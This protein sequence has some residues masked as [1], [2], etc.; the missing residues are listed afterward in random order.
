MVTRW[1]SA[2]ALLAVGACSSDNGVAGQSQALLPGNDKLCDVWLGYEIGATTVLGTHSDDVRAV[3]GEPAKKTE[4]EFTYDWCVGDGCEKRASAVLKFTQADRCY[5]D[6][7]KPI[8]PPMWLHDVTV[9]GFTRPK[10]W[11]V[12]SEQPQL[13]TECLAPDDAVACK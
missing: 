10:C 6:S 7:G 12:G 4:T 13:C 11:T 5:R 9:D 3:L 8:T 1:A 2:A